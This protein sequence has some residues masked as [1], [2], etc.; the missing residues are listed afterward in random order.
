MAS[1]LR[2][3][4][5]IPESIVDGPG[6]RYVVF[7]QGCPHHCKGCHNPQTHPFDGGREISI[8]EI[9]RDYQVNPLLA[10]ITFSGGEPFCQCQPLWELGQRIHDMGG[11]VIT[12]TGFLYEDLEE[13][14]LTD[15][16]VKG[17]LSVTDLLVDGPYIEELRSLDLPFRGSSNQRLIPLSGRI[18]P[19]L[20]S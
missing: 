3:H 4:D 2:I 11:T 17:L 7:T 15:P 6:L 5:I 16:D 19:D 1:K 13:K 20:L 10:G 8:E 14:A 9:C 12:Y 18:P